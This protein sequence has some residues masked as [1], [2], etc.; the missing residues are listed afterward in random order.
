MTKFLPFLVFWIVAFQSTIFSQSPI[1]Q[2]IVDDTNIDSLV[3]F[4][5]ELTGEISTVIGGLPYT[6]VSRHKNQPGNDKAADYIEQ[7]LQSY[8]LTVTNQI[9]SSSGRNVYAVQP[10]TE[11]PNQSFMICAHYDD[12]PSG[13]VAPGADDN[14]SG[15]AAVLEAARVF[16]TRS[17]PYTIIYALWDEEEQGLVGAEYYAGQA[18]SN[19]DS[20]LGVI[21]LDMIAWDSDN[22]GN[23][24]INIRAVANSYDLRD[25]MLE[26]NP[27]Y[28]INLD[29]DV[30]NP[31]T[32]ASDHAAFW[33]E[34]FSAV[35]LI[36][37]DDDFHAHYHTTNDLLIHYNVP[38]YEKM[39]KLAFATL[40][41]FALN[42][43]LK[44]SHSPIASQENTDD[45][46]CTAEIVTGFNIGSGTGAPRLYYKTF[47]GSEWSEF[48][49]VIGFEVSDNTTYNFTIPGQPLGTIVKY[50][51][52]AQDD[53][54][55]IVATL[56]VGGS[57]FDPPGST[58]PANLFQFF[59]AT[60]AFS[61]YAMNTDNWTITENWN[62]TAEK[63]VS[64][65]YSFTDSPNS[66]YL[67][68]K[69]STFKYD[70]I[71]D[72]SDPDLLGAYIE[73][74]TQWVIETDWDYGQF[75]IS[76]NSGSNWIPMTGL[77]TNLGVGNFQ[78]NGEPVYDG[79]QTTWVIESI[80]ISEFVDEQITF[81]YLLKTDQNVV[82]DGWYIDDIKVIFYE[83]V[84]VDVDN[85]AGIVE[86]YSLEQNYPNPFN[87]ST[88]IK[89]QIPEAGMVSLT[90][91]DILG[92]E[93]VSLVN[94]EKSPG[95]YEL[96]F[97]AT[98]ISSGI[99]FYTLRTNNYINTKK[100][101]LVK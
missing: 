69:T 12:M 62:T 36:E 101:I 75:E 6:I 89:F 7:K 9:W 53:Q 41:S 18:A 13:S 25:K 88:K 93:V 30:I 49:E 35:L 33:A 31:G 55:S 4:V 70:G 63:F 16:S 27:L 15:T 80:D 52:A 28:G 79:S 76:T 64:S 77:H 39:T 96:N 32:G 51:I 91:Y 86:E 85:I 56:P 2:S 50:Y 95:K 97:D 20:L 83:G 46:Q 73:F 5:E 47:Q 65:P 68:N 58:P 74:Q 72:L 92:K 60:I 22:D 87:P 23:A 71:I 82:R 81:R 44:I 26:C 94:E 10:G 98:G 21:N 1:V 29:L 66:N 57:G 45:I 90:V 42:L 17:F 84:T 59:V 8:G 43:N 34:G 100:M 37:D 54:G 3:Y 78:P 99:Y 24:D 11:F 14:A 67:S 38:Y 48:Y 61:D 19:G 40:A